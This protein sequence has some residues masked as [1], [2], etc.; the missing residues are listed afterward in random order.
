MPRR[1]A[2]IQGHPDQGTKRL[3]HALANA[4]AEGAAVAGHE[5]T[6]IEVRDSI[7]PSCARKRISSAEHL[8]ESPSEAAGPT[9]A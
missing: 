4:Y 5:I 3:C 9:E 6:R 8:P 2:L 7:S 1:V